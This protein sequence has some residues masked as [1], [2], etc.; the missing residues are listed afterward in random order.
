[1]S[2]LVYQ[3]FAQPIARINLK[4]WLLKVLLPY[5]SVL[6]LGIAIS[7]L[8]FNYLSVLVLLFAF[9]ILFW[10]A[11]RDKSLIRWFGELLNISD[12]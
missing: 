8:G 10:V 1:M 7:Q 5:F 9:G 3:F 12:R 6:I 2:L 4:L 11:F